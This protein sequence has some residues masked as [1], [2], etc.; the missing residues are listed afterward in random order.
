MSNVA[1]F[2]HYVRYPICGYC[3][4]AW[5]ILFQRTRSSTSPGRWLEY[6]KVGGCDPDV[7]EFIDE[8]TGWPES[9]PFD[10]KAHRIEWGEVDPEDVPPHDDR[11]FHRRSQF[12]SP[13]N[14]PWRKI[15]D[16][17]LAQAHE[18]RNLLK[19]RRA[20][21]LDLEFDDDEEEVDE[22]VEAVTLPNL[23]DDDMW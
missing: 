11:C 4:T 12:H 17:L 2:S 22:P 18:R 3:S 21:N 23:D 14:A 1:Q 10:S 16:K 20:A 19:A 6:C 5:D 9:W 13:D 15:S 7:W 8:A